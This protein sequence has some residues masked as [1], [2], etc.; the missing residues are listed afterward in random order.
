MST[1]TKLNKII[2]TI[3]LIFEPI[4]VKVTQDVKN[5]IATTGS[6][7]FY[8]VP[9]LY[10][11]EVGLTNFIFQNSLNKAICSSCTNIVSSQQCDMLSEYFIQTGCLTDKS[12]LIQD[13]LDNKIHFDTIV[14]ESLMSYQLK[15][16]T[17]DYN[18]LQ[19]FQ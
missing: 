15:T 16:L 6:L 8:S 1:Q 2:Y 13:L 18:C 17:L 10:L 4:P 9:N 11:T 3:H 14:N 19:C 7:S 5:V 12:R